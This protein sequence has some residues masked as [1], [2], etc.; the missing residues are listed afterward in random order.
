MPWRADMAIEWYVV[1][2]VLLVGWFRAYF[3]R[4][5]PRQQSCYVWR[6]I[7]WQ[8]IGWSIFAALFGPLVWIGSYLSLGKFISH[9]GWVWRKPK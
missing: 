9:H 2:F 8:S 7:V 5:W 6:N 1:W 4:N 3:W